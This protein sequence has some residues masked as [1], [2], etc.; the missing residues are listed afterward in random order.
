MEI[1][2]LGRPRPSPLPRAV[3]ALEGVVVLGLLRVVTPLLAHGQLVDVEAIAD[4]QTR[5][6]VQRSGQGLV[7]SWKIKSIIDQC[8]RR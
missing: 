4:I 1:L 8:F 6:K 5:A 7:N 2:T 3:L